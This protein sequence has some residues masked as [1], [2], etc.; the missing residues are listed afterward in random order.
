MPII[1]RNFASGQYHV[2]NDAP[3]LDTDLS[4]EAKGV[5]GYLFSKPADWTPRMYDI[6]DSGPCGKHKIRSVFKE[7]EEAGYLHRRKIRTDKGRFDWEVLIFD[8][9]RSDPGWTESTPDGVHPGRNGG[10]SNTYNYSILTNSNTDNKECSSSSKA[11][12]REGERADEQEMSSDFETDGKS[13]P[14]SETGSDFDSDEEISFDFV[15]ERHEHL[16]PQIESDWSELADGTVD[17]VMLAR[18]RLHRGGQTF[19]MQTVSHWLDR[20]DTKKCVAAWTI[21][22]VE[23]SHNPV[24]YA[25]TILK[26]DFIPHERNQDGRSD[27]DDEWEHFEQ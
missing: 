23:A 12:V 9:P 4:W 21:A 13:D 11:R 2:A 5:L 6:V 24:K 22:G 25:Q 8:H 27:A 17:A 1:K 7:L 20:Y 14:D 10:A 15:P 18:R 19:P 3:F 26:N 16:L